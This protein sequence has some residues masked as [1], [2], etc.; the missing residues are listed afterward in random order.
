MHYIYSLTYVIKSYQANEMM[1]KVLQ[2]SGYS[3]DILNY[4]DGTG[5]TK[6]KDALVSVLTRKVF[7]LPPNTSRKIEHSDLCVSAGVTAILH[8]LSM[9][10]FN[11]GDVV[12]VPTPYYPAFDH[13]LWNLSDV[14]TF[15]VHSVDDSISN[16]ISIE[17]L[18]TGYKKANVM[19]M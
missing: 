7:A 5:L 6:L 10:L 14:R 1:R 19:Q 12:L 3:K 16:S 8:E 15:E 17:A 2:F 9:L 13:D 18:E 4:T 11:P